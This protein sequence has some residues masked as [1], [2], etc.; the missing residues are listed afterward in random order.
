MNSNISD[1]INEYFRLT[2]RPIS[3]MSVSEY[4]EFL[5]FGKEQQPAYVSS[6]EQTV[7]ESFPNSQP[8]EIIEMPEKEN[9]DVN[10]EKEPDH[11]SEILRLMQAI[12]G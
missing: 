8:A 7:K 12:S 6:V 9:E 1:F 10:P 11:E 2:G 4:I 5:T 3:T